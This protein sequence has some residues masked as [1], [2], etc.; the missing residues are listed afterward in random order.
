[1]ES[2]KSDDPNYDQVIQLMRE[3]RD[4]L[5]QMA[6]ESWR[7]MIVEAIDLDI[8]SQVEASLYLSVSANSNLHVQILSFFSSFQGA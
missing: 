6:P 3:M 8:F 4:E 5:C 7:Q 1:M 2:M